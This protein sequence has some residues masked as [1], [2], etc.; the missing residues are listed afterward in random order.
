MTIHLGRIVPDQLPGDWYGV[1]VVI[2]LVAAVAYVLYWRRVLERGRPA[3]SKP[4]PNCGESVM[5]G[6]AYC[7]RCE[8][9]LNPRSGA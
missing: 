2:L 1:I 7:P 3:A 5:P 6:M 8:I 4:C 9:D